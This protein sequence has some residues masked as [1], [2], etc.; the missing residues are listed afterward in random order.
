[1]K[2]IIVL[3]DGM[4]DLP[5]AELNGF[6]PL[7]CAVKPHIDALVPFAMLGMVKTVPDGLPPGSDVANLSAMGFDP[8]LYYTGRSPLEAVSMGI[9]LSGTDVTFRCNLVNL[10]EEPS[11]YQDKLM[12]DY[13]SDEIT[14]E[15]AKQLIKYAASYFC[16]SSF[17]LYNGISYRHCLVA[18][19]FKGNPKLTPP[20]D[21]TGMKITKFLPDGENSDKL[22]FVMEQSFDLLDK[23]PINEA[24]RKKG[25]RAANS[26]WFWGQ[27]KKPSIPEFKSLYGLNGAVISAVDLLK[28][29]AISAG[30]KSIDVPGVTGNLH[31]DFKAKADYA[32][33][34]LKNGFDFVFIHV[35]APDECGHRCDVKGKIKAIEEIDGK[36]VSTLIEGLEKMEEEYSMLIMPDHPTPLSTMT[37]S[38]DN[39]PFVLYRSGSKTV[40]SL[41][42]YDEKN[43]AGSGNVFNSGPDLIKYFLKKS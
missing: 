14:S 4:S 9:K 16:D 33:A 1:M 2:F 30:M 39:V 35:E 15:E 28:G 24:R 5:V 21:I 36:V 7:E 41:K 29:I 13:S 26:L 6:T 25:L 31:T 3:G 42:R 40:C 43:C 11:R 12:V 19:D 38:R 10:S 22:R 37:H 32:L 8:L 34:A 17:K 20:H 27:G 18:A 23:H